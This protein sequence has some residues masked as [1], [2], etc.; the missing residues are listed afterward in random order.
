MNAAAVD[1][2]CISVEE[3]TKHDGQFL[4]LKPQGQFITGQQ[5]RDFFLK[6]GLPTPVLGHIWSLADLNADGKMDRKEFSIAVHL[7]K[8][9]LQGFELPKVLP[10]SLVADPVPGVTV[11]P[12]GAFGMPAMTVH[13]GQMSMGVPVVPLTSSAMPGYAGSPAKSVSSVS[14]DWAIPSKL[15][16]NQM[17]NSQDRARR[18]YLT[19][20]EAR[21]VLMQSG[22]P[23][24]ILAQVWNLADVDNDGRLTSEEFCLAM[25]LI[26]LA[27]MGQPLPAK[28]PPELVPPS[29]RRGRAGSGVGLPVPPQGGIASTGQPLGSAPGGMTVPL[30]GCMP[31]NDALADLLGGGFPPAASSTS[32][33]GMMAPVE[34]PNP[35]QDAEPPKFVTFEDKRKEN[36]DKGQAELEKRRA[37]LRELQ[38]QEEEAR[39]AAERAEHEKKERIRQEQE[40]KRQME[41]EKQFE[42]QRALEQERDEQRRKAWEQRE[43]A[44]RELERQRQLEWERQRRDQLV[45]EKQREQNHVDELQANVGKLKLELEALDN[46][47]ADLSEKM[48]QSRSSVTDLMSAIDAMRYT[49]DRKLTDIDRFQG[50]IQEWTDKVAVLQQE[51]QQLENLVQAQSGS[52]GDMVENVRRNCSVKKQTMERQRQSMADTEKEMR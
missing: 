38:H 50:D 1:P 33:G 19:G 52:L 17:F 15:K 37:Q 31:Q 2:W 9:K 27:K 46:R 25:H 24:P 42:K 40:R 47:K 36:F 51:R 10:P 18:G 7:I 30:P 34:L 41:L 35:T 5:A 14:G 3:R 44:R 4:Q 48:S 8:K 45:A 20:V 29:Y 26:D 16:Y 11:A 13:H 49:R 39:L 23:H 12:M 22:L 6:S 21:S 43:A 32:V 28:L